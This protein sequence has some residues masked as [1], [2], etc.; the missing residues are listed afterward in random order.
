MSLSNR[1]AIDRNRMAPRVPTLKLK[2][3]C[4]QYA[5]TP[6]VAAMTAKR[7]Q[8]R[9]GARVFLLAAV[10]ALAVVLAGCEKYR[11]NKKMAELCSV[12]GGV[13]VFEVVSVDPDAMEKI[14]KARP[15]RTFEEYYGPEYALIV[16]T[17]VVAGAPPS[18]SR[19]SGRVFRIET[20]IVRKSDGRLLGRQVKYGRSGGDFIALVHPSSELCPTTKDDVGNQVFKVEAR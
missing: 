18:G 10:G 20:Q 3:R 6:L 1:A 17:T 19:E 2:G 15:S 4:N 7:L 14:R 13:K 11:L 8:F 16:N 5:Y 12:D 9:R